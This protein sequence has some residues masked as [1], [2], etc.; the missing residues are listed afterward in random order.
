ERSRQAFR[1]LSSPGT[2]VHRTRL[3]PAVAAVGGN[4]R[5]QEKPRRQGLPDCL[6]PARRIPLE[7]VM[8]A[9]LVSHFMRRLMVAVPTMLAL[10][11]VVFVVLRLLPPGPLGMMLTPNAT[12]AEVEA[13]R[14]TM[15][16]DRSLLVQYGIWL[17]HVL[18][19][20]LA[21]SISSGVPVTQ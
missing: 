15:G 21:P 10:T 5:L 6:H 2:R 19:G 16:L 17:G 3:E 1:G 11:R 20:D 7:Q 14:H 8:L 18:Q 12:N 9:A 4:D 13:L